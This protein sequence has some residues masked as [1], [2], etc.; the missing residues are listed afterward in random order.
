MSSSA[1]LKRPGEDDIGSEQARKKARTTAPTPSAS[2]PNTTNAHPLTPPQAFLPGLGMNGGSGVT[3]PTPPSTAGFHS[4]MHQGPG[5]V[6]SGGHESEQQ[7]PA[8]EHEASAKNAQGGEAETAEAP[9]ADE[10]TETTGHR[11]TDHERKDGPETATSSS[12]APN[13]LFML[14]T[15]RKYRPCTLTMCMVC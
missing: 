10:A 9:Q 1:P 4:Q 11:R 2:P 14:P 6:G 13:S 12:S 3:I 15:K 8:E 5:S 7:T